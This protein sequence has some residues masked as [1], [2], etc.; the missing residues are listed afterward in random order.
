[1]K[2]I[3]FVGLI[4]AAALAAACGS[5]NDDGPES[6]VD[7]VTSVSDTTVI[8]SQR[9]RIEELGL[10]DKAE[11][12][13][14]TPFSSAGIPMV[15]FRLFPDFAK[16]VGDP[17]LQKIW[18]DSVESLPAFGLPA[19]NTD[20][21]RHALALGLGYIRSAKALIPGTEGTPLDVTSFQVAGLTC[22]ACHI[23]RIQ[24]GGQKHF[25][26]G[27]G[28]IE[29]DPNRFTEAL[30]KTVSHPKFT[31]ETFRKLVNAKSKLSLW[32]FDSLLMKGQQDLE[33]LVFTNT[34][35]KAK[36][37]D[38]VTGQSEAYASDI[39]VAKVKKKIILKEKLMDRELGRLY[40]KIGATQEM[41]GISSG[42]ADALGKISVVV[43][44]KAQEA[45]PVDL[46]AVWRQVDHEYSQYDGSIRDYFY[47]NLAASVGV[48]GA[49]A[50]EANRRPGCNGAIQSCTDEHELNT[51]NAFFLSSFVT[52]L[53]PPKWAD[54][55]GLKQPDAKSVARGAELYKTSCA[56]CHSTTA[57]SM[58][59][60]GEPVGAKTVRVPLTT[61][62]GNDPARAN[63]LNTKTVVDIGAFLQ[64]ACEN[65][66]QEFTNNGVTVRMKDHPNACK[67]DTKDILFNQTA[68]SSTYK[69]GI[70]YVGQRLNG[71]A[72]TA[73]YLHNGCVPNLR[74]L[75]VPSLRAKYKTFKRGSIE[76]DQEN[77]GYR[78]DVGTDTYDTSIP[79]NT[80]NGHTSSA[81]LGGRTWVDGSQDLTDIL[82]Y[83]KTL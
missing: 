49:L 9:A 77:V 4:S 8:P 2:R 12:F 42:Q 56:S 14:T 79:G 69:A 1:M 37:T 62:S 16:E 64:N 39:I 44:S 21:K 19:N 15:I 80:C 7:A 81:M 50:D 48:S 13:K 46:P 57:A 45:A 11:W 58:N 54:I 29:F 82:N 78:T 25:V 83:M 3:G 43:S 66:M 51:P 67:V 53:E 30:Y 41:H 33:T 61:D 6:T 28:N 47:R 60:K 17:E 23:S 68:D 36:D 22:G 31:G 24:V 52:V 72:W 63:Q 40:S 26:I 34:L 18:G 73:P 38:G 10:E 32:E 59:A 65:G 20:G 55:P 35:T 75:L 70:G 71:I 76:F 27:N 74:A 5:A